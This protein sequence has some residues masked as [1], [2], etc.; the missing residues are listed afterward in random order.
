MTPFDNGRATIGE[1]RE[2]GRDTEE[3]LISTLMDSDSPSERLHDTAAVSG[4]RSTRR[5][6]IGAA[7]TL[8]AVSSLIA[9]CSRRSRRPRR[10]R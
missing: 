1:D 9:V 7:S 4:R 2:A 6:L 8:A 5:L 3:T 10:K